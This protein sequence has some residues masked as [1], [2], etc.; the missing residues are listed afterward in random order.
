MPKLR[1]YYYQVCEF[2]PDGSKDTTFWESIRYIDIRDNLEDAQKII[3]FL[4][5]TNYNWA[6]YGI[7]LRPLYKDDEN[8]GQSC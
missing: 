7:V 6:S 5:E 2:C 4:N 1:G 3:D 8:V